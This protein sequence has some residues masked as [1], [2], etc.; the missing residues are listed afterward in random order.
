MLDMD[1]INIPVDR[2][3]VFRIKRRQLKQNPL[4]EKRNE[5]SINQLIQAANKPTWLPSATI[6]N[7][8]RSTV[9]KRRVA[10]SSHPHGRR[11]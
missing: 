10:S 9:I 1:V 3:T 11:W 7:S 8:Q 2:A 4:P 5:S 6:I